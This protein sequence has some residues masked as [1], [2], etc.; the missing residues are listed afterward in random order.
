ML[1]SA[2]YLCLAATDIKEIPFAVQ[3]AAVAIFKFQISFIP[4]SWKITRRLR[5]EGRMLDFRIQAPVREYSPEI[6]HKDRQVDSI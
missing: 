1:Q 2:L 6:L 3:V 4:T 5:G